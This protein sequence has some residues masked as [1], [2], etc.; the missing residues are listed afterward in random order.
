MRFMR[1][2]TYKR[3]GLGFLQ[4]LVAMFIMVA[5]AGILFNS[6]IAIDS[7]DG[8]K[9]YWLSPLDTEPEF[10]DSAVFR[11]IFETAVSDIT[12][13]VII[14]GQV[15]TDGVFD[16]HKAIDITKF[17]NRKGNGNGCKV[18]AK[19]EL[20]DLIKWGKYGIEYTN[21]SM[22][23]SDFVNYFGTATASVN[24]ALDESGQLYFAGFYDAAFWPTISYDAVN[25]QSQEAIAARARTLEETALIEAQMQKYTIEQLEDMAFSFIMAET[26]EDIS[27]TREED[28]SLT[29]YFPIVNGRYSTVDGE[30][31]L[32]AYA[33]N[34]VDYVKLQSNLE[35]AITNLSANYEMYQNCN[36]LYLEDKSNLKYV[37]RMLTEDG[38]KTYTNVS[39]MEAAEESAI[40]DY[41]SEYR[42]YLIYYPDSLEFT[43]NTSMT[44]EEIYSY[45]S[46]YEYAYPETTHIWIGVDTNYPIAGDAFYNANAVFQR[47]VPNIGFI[48]IFCVI[49]GL[50]WL[51]LNIYLTVTAGVV[52]DE[53][54]EM[55][56]YLNGFDRIWTEVM[57]LVSAGCAFVAYLGYKE[58][59]A[60]ADM[61]YASH[62]EILGANITSVQEYGSFAAYGFLFS[63]TFSIIWYS[64]VRRIKNRNLWRDSF[65]HWLLEHIR[66]GIY[67]VLS[68]RNTAVSTLI[69]YN[70]FILVNLVGIFLIFK[71]QK[72]G[73]WGLLLIVGIILFDGIIGVLLFKH[74]AE[75]LDIVDGIKRIRDGEV[76]Y[77]LEVETLHGDNREMADAVNNIGEGIRK[78]VNTSMKDEQMKTDLITNV[79]HDIKTPLTSIINYVDLLKRLDI[80]EEPAKSYIGILDSKSQRLKQLADDL[81]EASKIS[82]GNIEL[83]MEK[84]N[85]TELMNQAIGEFVDRLEEKK[86]TVVFDGGTTP[87]IIYADSRR[88]WRVIENLFHNVCKYA[89]EGTRVYVDMTVAE[90]KIEMS[91]KNI[92]D[93]QMNIQADDLTERFI[94]GDASR[95]TEG[96]G[97]GLF[98]AKSFTKVQ[99]GVFTIYLDGDLFKVTL[100]FPEYVEPLVQVEEE[101]NVE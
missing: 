40:T 93:R 45:L 72:N 84:L 36:P 64:F 52:Y 62:S 16:S 17:A 32:I 87:A 19:Y 22:S 79:S 59:L 5:I 99:G 26:T 57:L 43:G 78:A 1:K 101:P 83:N 54:N 33:G 37:V 55:V 58:L 73:I 8:N 24:Y 12:R 69:P 77:K 86:L 90:G 35:E 68:H 3:L 9:V 34:W 23:M 4:H 7:M 67:F 21:R 94:R 51:M 92:S 53:H 11:D 82:S 42:R 65:V 81:V 44:E 39:E 2:P 97:L 89:M 76:D 75:Q 60:I 27:L 95:T 30:N 14:K 28:G 80:E 48:L 85:L 46:E 15:E 18:T 74:K 96:S 88:M 38:V 63:M 91:M 47:I 100:C 66:R 31:Q 98:I 20:E 50:A 10:E 13:L 71:N 29:V 61:V 49:M 70:L 25:Y 56:H 6:Y 41:F